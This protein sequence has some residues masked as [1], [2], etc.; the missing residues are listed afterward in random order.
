MPLKS[1]EGP[2]LQWS[3]HY[4]MDKAQIFALCFWKLCHF[5]WSTYVWFCVHRCDQG[6]S[7]MQ[8]T[9]QSLVNIRKLTQQSFSPYLPFVQC[10]SRK[11]STVIPTVPAASE[12]AH[13]CCTHFPQEEHKSEWIYLWYRLPWKPAAEH[14]GHAIVVFHLLFFGLLQLKKGSVWK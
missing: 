4:Y 10:P 8:M 7:N 13:F 5:M 9:P 14:T 12:A 6:R 11:I 2:K 3:V 1:P